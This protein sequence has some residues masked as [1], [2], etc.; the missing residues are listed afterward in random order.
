MDINATLKRLGTFNAR[1]CNR[2]VPSGRVH[3]VRY[4]VQPVWIGEVR[5]TA[6]GYDPGGVRW[7]YARTNG[8]YKLYCAMDEELTVFPLLLV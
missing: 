8:G 6:S 5:L 1:S 4:P 7:T 2:V 3:I